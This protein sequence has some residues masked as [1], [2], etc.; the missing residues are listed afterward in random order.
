MYDPSGITNT[1]GNAGRSFQGQQTPLNF[2]SLG[3]LFG[4]GGAYGTGSAPMNLMPQNA[5]HQPGMNLP[6]MLSWLGSAFNPAGGGLERMGGQLPAGGIGASL[7]QLGQVFGG[8]R[9]GR[10][11]PPGWASNAG[12]GANTPQYMAQQIVDRN[13]RPYGT[14]GGE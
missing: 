9:G 11:Q 6:G 7:A 3:N 14:S 8:A 5:A 12:F 13:R 4:G 10:Q 2:S 1:T